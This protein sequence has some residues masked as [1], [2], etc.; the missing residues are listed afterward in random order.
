MSTP[1]V[2]FT[3]YDLEIIRRFPW[4]KSFIEY[5]YKSRYLVKEVP[6]ESVLQRLLSIAA[7]EKNDR[8]LAGGILYDLQNHLYSTVYTSPITE[9]RYPYIP[10]LLSI[11]NKKP[12]IEVIK[13]F[14]EK[15]DIILIEGA[16]IQHP[17]FFGLA[18]EI[19]VDLDVPTFGVTKNS[20]C[21]KTVCGQT[22][23]TDIKVTSKHEICPVRYLN[24]EVA[25]FVRKRGF[26]KGIYVSIGHLVS[27][28][29][30]LAI[31]LSLL[32]HRIPE[33]IRLIKG[34][35]RSVIREEM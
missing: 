23:T 1:E 18:C 33:P 16:G 8:I 24:R 13:H 26:V 31:T 5:Q 19:G 27:M 3:Q 12:L 7:F 11:R 22:E 32:T 15:F 6:K 17:R 2:L 20:L 30:I 10:S 34:Q 25:Y 35:L 28:S 21:G 29:S 9:T 4:T 14:K